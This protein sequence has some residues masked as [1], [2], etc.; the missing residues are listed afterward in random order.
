MY[1]PVS[2][3]LVAP[4]C[5]RYGFVIIGGGRAMHPVVRAAFKAVEP[6]LKRRVG[7]TPTSSAIS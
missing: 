6:L 4:R 5:I 7:S 2:L 3:R 1:S